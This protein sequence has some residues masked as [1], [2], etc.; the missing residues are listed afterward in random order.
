MQNLKLSEIVK[1]LSFPILLV[2]KIYN[3]IKKKKEY[4]STEN[5]IK[6]TESKNYPENNIIVS[7]R[8][9]ARNMEIISLSVTPYSYTPQTRELEVFTNIEISSSIVG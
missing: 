4:E 5:K 9:R 8:M 6:N 3:L 1:I 2:K 7:E